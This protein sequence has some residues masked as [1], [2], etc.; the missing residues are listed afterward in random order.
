MTNDEFVN[1]VKRTRAAQK[2]AYRREGRH[3]AKRFDELQTAWK[4]EKEVD[5]EIKARETELNNMEQI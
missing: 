4:L 2:I 1:L 5:T 3:S